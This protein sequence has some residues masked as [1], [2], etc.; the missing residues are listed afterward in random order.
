MRSVLKAGLHLRL[1][2]SKLLATM[3]S[4]PTKESIAMPST[5]TCLK[6]S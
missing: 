1:C 3:L 2:D 5:H 6:I 4:L